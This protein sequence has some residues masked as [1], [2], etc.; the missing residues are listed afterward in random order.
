MPG[1]DQNRPRQD[2]FVRNMSDNKYNGKP[3]KLKPFLKQF[4]RC[5]KISQLSPADKIDCLPLLLSGTASYWFDQYEAATLDAI[6]ENARNQATWEA[7]KTEMTAQFATGET[8]QACK[9]ELERRKQKEGEKYKDYYFDVLRLCGLVDRQMADALKRDYLFSGLREDWRN[10][11]LKD[12]EEPTLEQINERC[13]RWC[14]AEQLKKNRDKEGHDVDTIEETLKKYKKQTEES[15]AK[16]LK[17]AQLTA[18]PTEKKAEEKKKVF[19]KNWG[20]GQRNNA[21]GYRASQ[22]AYVIVQGDADQAEDEQRQ[23]DDDDDSDDDAEGEMVYMVEDKQGKL[24]PAQ[25]LRAGQQLPQR[26][27]Y[28]MQQPSRQQR[29]QQTTSAGNVALNLGAAGAS[30]QPTVSIP[31][32]MLQKLLLQGGAAAGG[33]GGGQPTPQNSPCRFCGHYGHWMKDCRK[34]A[35]A[36]REQENQGKKEKSEN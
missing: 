10:D 16:M 33:A 28:I 35:A 9:T 26:S 4:E 32:D 14:K 19:V 29:Q 5:A 17:E 31:L 30:G 3:T 27:Q 11:I 21:T 12:I 23:D 34:L 2:Q 8:R 1:N 20:N 7:V 36:E 6:A 24:H 22:R 15:F 13:V 18:Q 25:I